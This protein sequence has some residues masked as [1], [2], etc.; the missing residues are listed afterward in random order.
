MLSSPSASTTSAGSSSLRVRKRASLSAKRAPMRWLIASAR[1]WVEAIDHSSSDSSRLISEPTAMSDTTLWVSARAEC[2]R[3]RSSQRR[4]PNSSSRTS[5]GTS[6]AG[7]GPE[8]NTRPSPLASG[9]WMATCMNSRI[10]P[11][12]PI[13]TSGSSCRLIASAPISRVRRSSTVTGAGPRE[14]TGRR[15]VMPRPPSP[16]SPTC[17][18]GNGAD[19]DSRSLSRACSSAARLSGWVV[20]S[21]HS[22]SS[23][24]SIGEI[25]S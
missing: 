16:A 12:R 25:S 19:I 6:C 13:R 21:N 3:R 4:P 22:S 1:R 10:R 8:A 2:G 7:S 18:S 20:R 5:A 17:S 11:C 9:S 14:Y 23:L 15:R 24:P